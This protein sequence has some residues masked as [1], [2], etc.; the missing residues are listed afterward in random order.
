MSVAFVVLAHRG[1]QQVA[2]LAGRLTETGD[3]VVVHVDRRQDHEPF[4][5]AVQQLRR[6]DQVHLMPHRESVPCKW[7][8]YSLVDATLRC[9]RTALQAAPAASHVVLL[10]GQDYPLRST[11]EIDEFFSTA[12]GRSY[13]FYA[14]ERGPDGMDRTGNAQWYWN[15]KLERL[16]RFHIRVGDRFLA[17][18]NKFVPW[19]PMRR[20][21][22]G[23]RPCQGSQ[24]F[25]LHRDAAQYVLDYLDS[26]P[27]AVRF[28]RHVQI[29]DE[30]A[31]HM[32][33]DGSPHRSTV[34]QDDLHWIAW[35]R[36]HPRV[37][38]ADDLSAMLA[39]GKLFARKFDDG[40]AP[41]AL[42]RLDALHARR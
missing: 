15:G 29:P 30:N 3:T 18:P 8:D 42:D 5:Q 10:S 24:W 28:F 32:V 23:L 7:G 36:E 17:L 2:R 38:R 39:T 6:A 34:V 37:L 4:R 22:S 14:T 11:A 16:A 9:V 21:P 35:E 40:R 33:I 31:V 26:H 13:L 25:A 41:E 12:A 20:M 27:R 1:P 19:W